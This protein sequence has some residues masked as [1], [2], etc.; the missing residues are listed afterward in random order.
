M[1]RILQKH[2]RSDWSVENEISFIKYYS[3]MTEKSFADVLPN[4]TELRSRIEANQGFSFLSYK[5]GLDR[6]LGYT[7]HYSTENYTYNYLYYS[8]QLS[9]AFFKYSLH[10]E[11]AVSLQIAD[12][13]IEAIGKFEENNNRTGAMNVV[14]GIELALI[15]R[16]TEALSFYPSIPFEFTEKAAH[17]DIVVE[18]ILGFFQLLL[19]NK[20]VE[21]TVPT[22]ISEV[23]KHLEWSEYKKYVRRTDFFD[24][25]MWQYLLGHRKEKTDF[26]YIP[27]LKI[28]HYIIMGKQAEFENSVYEALE[29]WKTY[30]TKKY[31]E[32]GEKFDRS[33][34]PEGYWC[35]P[36]IA[37]CAYA[38]D[39]GMK[40][41]TVESDYLCDWMIEG[42]FEEFELLVKG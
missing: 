8:N 12:K 32:Q 21:S 3:V 6:A 15:L 34:E 7:G 27:L 39:K 9:K 37:A 23:R 31:V 26:L 42:R 1:K 5:N 11:Q 33:F 41:Q 16:D 35:I 17:D 24:D 2:N 19:A 36:V 28:Y 4:I 29:Q 14:R 38:N 13:T 30:Y 25:S 20:G 22:V 18:I 10:D 40:L